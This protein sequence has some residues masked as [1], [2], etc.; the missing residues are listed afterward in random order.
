MT[1]QQELNDHMTLTEGSSDLVQGLSC[2]PSAPQIGFLLCRKPPPSALR[3]KHHL[4]KKHSYQMVLLRPVELAR[5]IGT[6]GGQSFR[7][8]DRQVLAVFTHL[9]S[10][11]ADNF[12]QGVLLLFA[13]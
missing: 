7:L 11:M 12:S 13:L 8:H 9:V 5:L 10:Q 1:R 3:H 4:W 6:W 2:L